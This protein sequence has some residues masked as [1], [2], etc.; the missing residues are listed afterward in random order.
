M[1]QSLKLKPIEMLRWD[2]KRAVHKWMTADL[3]ELKQWCKEDYFS[4]FDTVCW[5]KKKSVGKCGSDGMPLGRGW[6]ALLCCFSCLCWAHCG[7]T[8]ACWSLKCCWTLLT[9]DWTTGCCT[10]W[11]MFWFVDILLTELL[12]ALQDLK[13]IDSFYFY[14]L[15]EDRMKQQSGPPTSPT[16]TGSHNMLHSSSSSSF[17]MI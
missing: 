10:A 16:T 8:V 17:L 9:R 13:M 14:F 5:S 6:R 11:G 2:L 1:A 15:L 3:K 12:L 7:N 4:L